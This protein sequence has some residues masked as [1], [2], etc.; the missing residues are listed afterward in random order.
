MMKINYIVYVDLE[1][2]FY[3]VKEVCDLF[4]LDMNEL[5][6]YSKKFNILPEYRNST[7]GFDRHSLRKLHNEIYRFCK[8]KNAE[9]NGSKEEDEW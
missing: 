9:N 4:G 8:A 5:K 1:D 3:S 6:K 7:R 2:R